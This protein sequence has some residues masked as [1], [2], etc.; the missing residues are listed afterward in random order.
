[1][2][3]AEHTARTELLDAIDEIARLE[4]EVALLKSGRD[5]GNEVIGAIRDRLK[6][7][8]GADV[9]LGC[10]ALVSGYAETRRRVADLDGQLQTSRMAGQ[11][12]YRALKDCQRD[13]ARSEEL[14]AAVVSAANHAATASAAQDA[15]YMRDLNN[16]ANVMAKATEQLSRMKALAD[17]AVAWYLSHENGY[18][19]QLEADLLCTAVQAHM[20]VRPS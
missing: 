13:L 15:T 19:A 5:A 8:F 7:P 2:A 10:D 12:H 4:A 9:R 18:P 11:M 17:A 16:H 3:H 1:M 20:K 14:R 6:L